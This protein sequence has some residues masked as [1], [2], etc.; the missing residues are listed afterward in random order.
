MTWTYWSRHIVSHP[1]IHSG[2]VWLL[3][4]L[5]IALMKMNKTS[6]QSIPGSSHGQSSDHRRGAGL[7][8]GGRNAV[9]GGGWNRIC[10]NQ[11]EI[12][13]ADPAFWFPSGLREGAVNFFTHSMYIN[14]CAAIQ[15]KEFI[16]HI[17]FLSCLHNMNHLLSNHSSSLCA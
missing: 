9:G 12:N 3:I 8:E 15:D 13:T 7:Q 1:Q 4:S 17:Q 11:M 10:N 5:L 14:T 16:F 6:D 2:W